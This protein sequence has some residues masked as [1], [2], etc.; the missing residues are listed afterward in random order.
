[1]QL[2]M[3]DDPVDAI[4]DV[5]FETVLTMVFIATTLLLNRSFDKFV[6]VA[7]GLLVCDNVLAC[8][9]LPLVAW[10]T[11]SES[12]FSYSILGLMFLWNMLIVS[13]IFNR[14]LKINTMASLVMGMLYFMVTYIGT[15][16][17]SALTNL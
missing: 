6:Q 16:Y 8:L 10:I 13:Y 7:S 9:S 14:V 2:N 5:T 4:F 3:I 12:L 11:I 17:L 15:F 1:M